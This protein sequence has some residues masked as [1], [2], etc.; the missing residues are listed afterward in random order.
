VTTCGEL[1]ER[2]ESLVFVFW[3]Q[4]DDPASSVDERGHR[5]AVT[6]GLEFDK[7]PYQFG[8]HAAVAR[9][10]ADLDVVLACEPV[11]VF[12]RNPAKIFALHVL[13]PL[14]FRGRLL[15]FAGL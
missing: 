12:R 11:A 9:C 5:D 15:C 1:V 10:R 13:R 4:R 6:G 7:E 2:A 3:T 8:I 14:S